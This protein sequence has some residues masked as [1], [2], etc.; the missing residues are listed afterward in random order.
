MGLSVKLVS[1]VGKRHHIPYELMIGYIFS[2]LFKVN[3]EGYC[4]LSLA[5]IKEKRDLAVLALE[6]GCS[7]N[8]PGVR[9]ALFFLIRDCRWKPNINFITYLFQVSHAVRHLR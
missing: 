7:I 9:R 4:C 2:F 3:K 6:L 1:V 5:V 8:S